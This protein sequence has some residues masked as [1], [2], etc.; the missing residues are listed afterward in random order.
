[1]SA[2]TIT[3]PTTYVPPARNGLGQHLSDALQMIK[4]N[5][6]HIPRTPELLL[7]V[8]VQPVMF[9][10]LFRYVF[11]GA[12]AVEGG[13]YVNY[14]MAGILVQTLV[15]ATITTG[16]GLANDLKNGLIDRF[17][18]LPMSRAA[19]LVGR[20]VTDLLRGII[21]VVLMTLVGF[22]VG[23]RPDGNLFDWLG[24]FGLLLLF[25]FAFSWIGV[26]VGMAARSPEAVQAAMF[27]GVFP[28]T[29]ASSAFVPV[30]TMPSWLR[31]FAANQPVTLMV[32]ALRSALLGQGFGSAAWQTL[33]WSIGLLV[34]FFPIAIVIYQRRTSE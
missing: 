23:F 30:D 24:G 11:G 26:I 5:L 27:I 19:V 33:I 16:I 25:S 3:A 31:G 7:D 6:R 1:M 9:V 20:T 15:F 10:L 29:F 32:D 14:L 8:T 34:V 13:S 2:A 21:A 22:A 17:R 28:L 12:I 4:R 18:S